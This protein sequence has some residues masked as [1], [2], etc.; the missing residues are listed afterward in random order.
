MDGAKRWNPHSATSDH[1][2]SPQLEERE[3]EREDVV[4][5]LAAV[6][7]VLDPG[8]LKYSPRHSPRP[9]S[10]VLSKLEDALTP[11]GRHSAR[12]LEMN[13]SVMEDR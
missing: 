6:H 5:H 4:A 1:T 7:S 2:H 3:G 13:C 9:N 8:S 10:S 11:R 12:S